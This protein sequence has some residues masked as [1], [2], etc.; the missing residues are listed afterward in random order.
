MRIGLVT[1]WYPPE[2]PALV[3]STWARGLAS[4]GH[5]VHVITG[6]PNYPTGKVYDGYSV[7]PYL[8]EIDKDIT[9]HRGFLYPS[10][11]SNP[12]RRVA[13]YV[14]FSAG[15]TAASARAPR[16]DVWLTNGTPAT[17]AVP[18]ILNRA[19]HRGAHAMVIQDL[20][21]ESVT[22]SGFID[23]RLG[24]FANSAIDAYCNTMYRNTDAIGVISPGMRQVLIDRGV[25]SSKI[26]YTPNSVP[27]DHLLPEATSASVDRSQ[28]GLPSGRLFMFAGNFGQM[29]NL[30]RLIEAFRRV[31]E[32]QLALVGSGVAEARLRQLSQGAEN[33]T[34]VGRQNLAS[35]GRYIA[36]SD[37]QV[38]SLSDTP[39]LRVTMP[40]KFQACLAASRP[41]MA[42]ASGDVANI[43]ANEGVGL[44]A[45][46]IDMTAAETTIRDFLKLPA[47]VLREMGRTAR[48]LYESTYAPASGISRLES[49]IIAARD[50][51]LEGKANLNE[52]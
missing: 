14:S 9:V 44:H 40:S 45:S 36:A 48:K 29:Q 41:I 20:W 25:D 19:V 13:N 49:L 11:D 17:A 42:H 3:P 27:D 39:L 51:R 21:P 10:H 46:P 34:F 15:G 30:E 5:E 43:T 52:L 8:K 28:L 12:A 4:R 37:I 26:H 16:P 1:Q 50:R 2:V 31:P 33:I 24:A 47:E 7:R 35:I 22:Q 38:V 23:S 32:A 6:I 18:A